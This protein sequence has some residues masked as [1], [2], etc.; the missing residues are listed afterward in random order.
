MTMLANQS[1]TTDLV[2]VHFSDSLELSYQKMMS[3]GV[4][5]LPVIDDENRIVG[6]ISDRDFKRAEWPLLEARDFKSQKVPTFKPT[7]IVADYMNWPVTWADYN[8]NLVD[9]AQLMVDQ[10]ISSVLI[11]NESKLVGIVTHE[12]L[13]KALISSL[14]PSETNVDRL[15]QWAYNSPIGQIANSLAQIGI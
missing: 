13:L 6:I 7:S 12:D 9:I 3:A 4:R 8:T 14:K 1:M 2:V 10:K 15:K 5:H 11:H